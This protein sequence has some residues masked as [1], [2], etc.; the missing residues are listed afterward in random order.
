MINYT[1]AAGKCMMSQINCSA[2]ALGLNTDPRAGQGG[3]LPYPLP[4]KEQ[5]SPTQ[6]SLK[7]DSFI[8]KARPLTVI[9]VEAGIVSTKS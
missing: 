2:E 6:K 5:M 7:R 9:F 3:E 1:T 8:I 4:R